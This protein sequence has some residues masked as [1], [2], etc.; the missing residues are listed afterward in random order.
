MHI[1]ESVAVADG[2]DR[3][4]GAGFA[5]EVARVLGDPRG[6]R[7]YGYTFQEVPGPRDPKSRGPGPAA[8]PILIRL[9]PAAETD[10]RCG[11]A[12]RGLSCWVPRRREININERNWT[13]GA[14]SGL[15]PERYHNYVIS[16]EVG[17]AL[18]LDHAACPLAEC[19]RR[20][21]DP[22]P[23]SVMQQMTKG[24]P[25]IAPCVANDWPLD[26]EPGFGAGP[27]LG[28]RAVLMIVAALIAVVLAVLSHLV[29]RLILA[30][31][32]LPATIRPESGFSQ[33]R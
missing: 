1:T 22:C 2:V 14:A 30:R 9:A 8:G 18:G 3:A 5:A 7:K 16:H 26:F 4:T 15:A 24:G 31:V 29:H 19:A 17:H 20:G 28:P 13:T 25:A 27:R 6:W 21:L 32:N 11:G 33:R 23:A 10:R 12:G